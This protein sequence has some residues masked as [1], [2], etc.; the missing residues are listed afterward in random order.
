MS[1]FLLLGAGFSRN[2]GGWLAD[3]VV[4]D[5]GLRVDDELNRV[6]SRGRTFE[7]ALA[8]IQQAASHSQDA[9]KILAR[10]E[11][12]I[13]ATFA[14][15]NDGYAAKATLEFSNDLQYSIVKYLTRFDAI[16]TLN[17]DLLLELHYQRPMGLAGY[18]RFSGL[19]FPG[20][21]PM[22]DGSGLFDPRTTTWRVDE[23][24]DLPANMQPIF[25][26]HGSVNWRDKDG[27]RLLVMGANKITAISGS[28]VLR[29]YLTEFEKRLSEG[30]A[31]LMTI[32]YS[33]MDRH[34]NEII[35]RA[36]K[37]G[38]LKLFIVGLDGRNTIK[39]ANRSY[40]KPLYC[41]EEL[42]E[43][44]ILSD[45]I[46]L[47]SSTFGGSDPIEFGKFDRFFQATPLAT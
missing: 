40:G 42:D 11:T 33:F 1:R 8:E 15:M 24:F 32:G 3:E 2:W 13:V 34:I 7:D 31:R 16:F 23:Q 5:L 28:A 17:Q 6:L 36:A 22:A 45:S 44:Q 14:Y 25:K 46:R 18:P 29:R 43:V 38:G 12:A 47:I 37:K 30:A 41:P 4:S 35:C 27:E 20:M 10:L 19:H 39:K 21:R 9:R 26:L